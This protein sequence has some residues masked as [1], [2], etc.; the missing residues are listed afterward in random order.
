MSIMKLFM[1]R[2]LFAVLEETMSEYQ[3]RR[4]V[5]IPAQADGLGFSN[6]EFVRA[7][8]PIHPSQPS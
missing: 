1:V 5:A 6:R 3:H 7:V 2:T 8:G 4:C